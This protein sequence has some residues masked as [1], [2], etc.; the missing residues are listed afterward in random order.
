[1]TGKITIFFTGIFLTIALIVGCGHNVDNVET[2][3][4][5]GKVL[6]VE[7]GETEIY[8][9]TENDKTLELYF[10]DST[11][12]IKSGSPA[13][14]SALEKNTKVEVK[15]EKKGRKLNPLVVKIK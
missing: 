13:D 6:E 5:E 14:F 15:V 4:Y 12:L 11:K 8:V 3:T 1:M 2:G 7:P 9:K 10:T